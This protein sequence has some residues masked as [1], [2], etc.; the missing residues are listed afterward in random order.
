MWTGLGN[1]YR[2]ALDGSETVNC[3]R[4]AGTCYP[5]RCRAHRD[6]DTLITSCRTRIGESSP[7]VIFNQR[8]WIDWD[9]NL[10]S[11]ARLTVDGITTPL[12]A[13]YIRK[14]TI[15]FDLGA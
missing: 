5:D 3:A 8:I 12:R 2:Y 15:L 11:A 13:T 1:T 6:A 10:Q 7:E 4:S 14:G 9:G